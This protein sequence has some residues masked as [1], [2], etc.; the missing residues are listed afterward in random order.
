MKP[1][2]VRAA[3]FAACRNNIPSLSKRNTASNKRFEDDAIL[4]LR[5]HISNHDQRL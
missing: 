2:R 1:D 4:L 5:D 3:K